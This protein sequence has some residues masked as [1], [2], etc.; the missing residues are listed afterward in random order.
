[1]AV[2]ESVIWTCTV[3]HTGHPRGEVKTSVAG[4]FANGE[5]DNMAC[6][7]RKDKGN[8]KRPPRQ[9]VFKREP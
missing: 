3:C 7:T 1:M 9:T 5:C 4:N 6:P 8:K 2:G